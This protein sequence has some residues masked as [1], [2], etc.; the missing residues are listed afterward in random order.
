MLRDH[1][2]VDRV[3]S[4]IAISET[5]STVL[6]LSPT[7]ADLLRESASSR[8]P[9]VLLT[10]DGT[11]LTEPLRSA[12]ALTG[13]RWVV[14]TAGG[15]RDGLTARP[16]PDLGA[17]LRDTPASAPHPD[18][19]FLE[20]PTV[21]QLVVSAS[22]R[23]RADD[24][25]RV[26]GLAEAVA[27]LGGADA[28]TGWGP[29]EPAE[30]PWDRDALTAFA[31][32]RLPGDTRVSVVGDAAHPLVGTLT[33]RRTEHGVEEIGEILVSAGDLADPETDARLDAVPAMLAALAE[34]PW[35]LMALVF[36]RPGRDDLA[37]T[38]FVTPPAAPVALL[39]GAPAARDLRLD[40]ERW[41]SRFGARV[42]GRSRVPAL[43][44][45]LRSSAEA[46]DA[47][48][49]R[50]LDVVGEVGIDRVEELS[51]LD[52]DAERWRR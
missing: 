13:A 40:V 8:E 20:R 6:G 42:V 45:T 28:P 23:H 22:L 1:P 9:L 15:L 38:A 16:L 27:R 11:R 43:L 39:V 36:A 51:G 7:R 41:R 50:L 30:N 26:G 34:H 48:W 10:G 17:L 5:R 18:A 12:L 24:G 3:E 37:T 2:L 35:P 44:V 31:R 32:G 14:E 49:G 46:I 29:H 19:L 33:V 47:G 21:L 4:G 52:L 25:L